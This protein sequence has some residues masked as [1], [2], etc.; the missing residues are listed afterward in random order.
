MSLP[1]PAFSWVLGIPVLILRLE[2]LGTLPTEPFPSPVLLS[3]TLVI[4]TWSAAPSSVFGGDWK[5]KRVNV[6][7]GNLKQS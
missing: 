3:I 2:C 1:H 4:P 5:N 6:G 7:C